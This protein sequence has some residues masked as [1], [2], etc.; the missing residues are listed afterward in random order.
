MNHFQSRVRHSAAASATALALVT[1][2]NFPYDTDRPLSPVE[3]ETTRRYYAEAFQA[4]TSGE[5]HDTKYIHVA[6]EAARVFRIREQITAFADEFGLRYASV[7]EIGSGR[8][9]LQDVVPDYTGLDISPAVS[10]FYH[11]PFVMGSATAMPFPNNW[12]DGG[13]SIWVLEH[14]PNPE[15]A[16]LEIRRVMKNKAVVFLMPAWNCEPWAAGGYAV[17]SYDELDWKGKLIKASIPVRSSLAFN[18]LTETPVRV[19]RTMASWLGPTRLHYQRL[20]PNYREFWQA[21]SDA[22]NRLSR[23]EMMLWFRTRGDECLN[24]EERHRRRGEPLIIRI[25]K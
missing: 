4:R 24:C 19:A 18:L 2:A 12:F 25:R 22:V 16:L 10:R 3:I 11:K 5:A 14:V 21:D 8:G 17:R 23:R 6:A 20:Q 13:W 9:D 1:A 15:Q 7:L